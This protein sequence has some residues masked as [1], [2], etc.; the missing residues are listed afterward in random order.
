MTISDYKCPVDCTEGSDPETTDKLA[1][2]IA[3]CRSLVSHFGYTDFWACPSMPPQT[4]PFPWGSR[5]PFNTWFT[6]LI[7]VPMTNSESTGLAIVA[8]FMHGITNRHTYRPRYSICI[9]SLH[10]HGMYVMQ[11]KMTRLT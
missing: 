9:N 5:L 1:G 4:C 6:G 11:P 2:H 10:S 3:K 8:G 7:Q